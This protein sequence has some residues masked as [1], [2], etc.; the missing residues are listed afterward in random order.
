MRLLQLLDLQLIGFL[1]DQVLH[2]IVVLLQFTSHARM[3]A[4]PRRRLNLLSSTR[5]PSCLCKLPF[6]LLHFD[7]DPLLVIN[8]LQ[9]IPTW[10]IVS[11]ACLRTLRENLSML[12]KLLILP[13]VLCS[14]SAKTLNFLVQSLWVC[15][16]LLIL[17]KELFVRSMDLDGFLNFLLVLPYVSLQLLYVILKFSYMGLIS[18][19]LFSFC[20]FKP[21]EFLSVSLGLLF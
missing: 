21:F 15:L 4:L 1:N 7:Y 20:V 3:R 6:Q 9:A 13:I 8:S 16:Q 14:L 11:L 2:R 19:F 18:R 17:L 12:Q 10:S 5:F